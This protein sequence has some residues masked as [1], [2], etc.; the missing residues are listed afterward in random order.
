ME[1]P[2]PKIYESIE[3]LPHTLPVFPLTGAMML[4]RARLPLNIF[5]PRYLAMIDGA[6]S[7]NRV[8]G[9]IQPRPADP[10]TE[11]PPLYDVGCAG[12]LTQFAETGDG[13]YLITLTGI[14]RFRVKRELQ[15]MTLYR[16]VE[17]NWDG[18]EN[19]LYPDESELPFERDSLVDA[20]KTYFARFGQEVDWDALR[21]A[22]AEAMVGSLTAV[23][24]FRPEEKQALLEAPTL[25][26]RAEILVGLIEMAIAE[27]QG[28]TR[29]L[30]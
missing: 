26:Q 3:D 15:V 22:P 19:D 29:S 8:V 25:R 5:E 6:L 11:L 7:A 16:Q 1:T 27:D 9:M 21:A 13:R 23:C 24:P 17:A 4:P 20:L 14:C 28:P 10:G 12:R 18:F 2:G 30:Q